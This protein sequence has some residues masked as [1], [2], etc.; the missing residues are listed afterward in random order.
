MA[1]DNTALSEER[2]KAIADDS[3]DVDIPR[4]GKPM[5]EDYENPKGGSM[6]H[7]CVHDGIYQ[8]TWSCLKLHKVDGM[9]TRQSFNCAGRRYKVLV[10]VWVDVPPEVTNVLAM[11][12]VQHVKHGYNLSDALGAVEE[13]EVVDETPRFGYSIIPSA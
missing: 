8:P 7:L 4:P 6:G 13:R 5:P 2:M 3:L 9:P 11:A 1:D 12:N 10:G